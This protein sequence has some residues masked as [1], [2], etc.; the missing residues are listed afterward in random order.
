MRI[1]CRSRSVWVAR[2]VDAR[3]ASP[4]DAAGSTAAVLP[5]PTTDWWANR[6]EVTP[7]VSSDRGHPPYAVGPNGDP[8]GRRGYHRQ[9]RKIGQYAAEIAWPS[10][11]FTRYFWGQARHLGSLVLKDR[12]PGSSWRRGSRSGH[13]PPG[14]SRGGIAERP[15]KRLL[16]GHVLLDDESTLGALVQVVDGGRGGA[17][18]VA[19]SIALVPARSHHLVLTGSHLDERDLPSMSPTGSFERAVR[20]R[21]RLLLDIVLLLLSL[22]DR[23]V[24]VAHRDW[25]AC[26]VAGLLCRTPVVFASHGRADVAASRGKQCAHKLVYRRQLFVTVS[27][28]ARATL[29]RTL[30]LDSVVVENGVPIPPFVPPPPGEPLRL[31]YLGRF[32]ALQ[33]RPDIPVVVT[34]ALAARGINVE[35]TMLGDGPLARELESLARRCGVEDRITFPGWVDNPRVYLESAH[36][37]LHCTRWE[38]NPLSVLEALAA[39]RPVVVSRVPGTGFLAEVKGVELVEGAS[40]TRDAV[41]GFTAAVLR[42]REIWTARSD[43]QYFCAIHEAANERFSLDRMLSAWQDLLSATQSRA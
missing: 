7:R 32:E 11:S 16:G 12:R 1:A 38:G 18:T 9:M 27:D 42:I 6:L 40:E 31:L 25:L 2:H 24:L 26:R 30:G 34:A 10:E 36:A 21:W 8:E 33:K 14:R 20:G 15:S 37:V 28:D 22:H 4:P 41:E 43:D 35:T 5:L 29:K 3:S 19:R 13:T 23:R 39:G 17:L